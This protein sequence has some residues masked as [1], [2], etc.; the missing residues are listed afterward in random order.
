MQT[1]IHGGDIYSAQYRL[2][3]STNI[4]PLGTPQSVRRAVV[5]S[6]GELGHYPD[7]RCRELRAALSE[8]LRISANWIICGNGAAELIFAVA[9]AVHP[10]SALLICP[11]FSEYEK[12]LRVSGCR[13]IRYYL[14]TRGQGF[15][16]GED[17]LER[18]DRDIDMMY[19]CNPVNPTG[20]RIGQDLMVR[21]MEK[22]RE[23][24]VLLVMDESYLELSG[25]PED[26]SLIGHVADD[27]YLLVIRSFTKTYAMPGI[28]LG[29][30]ITSNK[31]LRDQIHDAI[32]PWPASI[33]AQRAGVAALKETDYLEESRRLIRRERQYLMQQFDRI[34]ITYYESESNFLFFEGPEDL[35]QQCTKKGILIRDCSSFRSL[36]PG[37]YRISIHKRRD[38]EELCG[39]LSDIYRAAGHFLT[40]GRSGKTLF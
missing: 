27:P 35:L 36:T 34:G 2:D 30:C 14:C 16:V 18:I 21:I 13:D 24:H 32:Q 10:H 20:V 12:A 25:Q 9:M 15:K 31:V 26:Y 22:C 40:D 6:V 19:L 17:I 38:N 3:F 23:N 11:G 39:V 37:Y 29:Y 1:Q 5:H 33:P 4:N 7:V 28:R 8:N